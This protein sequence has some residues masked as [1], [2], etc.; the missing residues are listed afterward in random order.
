MPV[1]SRCPPRRHVR[2]PYLLAFAGGASGGPFYMRGVRQTRFDVMSRCF[3]ADA[4]SGA[5]Q[6]SVT[7]TTECH[8]RS[9]AR[10]AVEEAVEDLWAGVAV[11]DTSWY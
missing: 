5:R 8:E 3:A 4:Q 11:R 6:F 9:D 2:P 1:S 10:Q 7:T